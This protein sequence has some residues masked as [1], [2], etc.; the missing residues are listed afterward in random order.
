MCARARDNNFIASN[1]PPRTKNEHSSSFLGRETGKC[2]WPLDRREM[3]TKAFG[4]IVKLSS[5]VYIITVIAMRSPAVS[6]TCVMRDVCVC[7]RSMAHIPV[8]LRFV[9][10]RV[11]KI[12]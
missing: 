5:L 10:G 9:V 8:A 4:R 11:D 1:T 2:D 3:T 7:V 6:A 12:L